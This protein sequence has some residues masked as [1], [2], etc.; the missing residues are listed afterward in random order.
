[1]VTNIEPTHVNNPNIELINPFQ[2]LKI[3]I[4]AGFLTLCLSNFV[5]TVYFGLFTSLAMI[6]AMIGVL[7]TLPSILK[8]QK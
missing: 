4:T 1:M 2:K 3:I 8:Y 5:P 6:F 7:I